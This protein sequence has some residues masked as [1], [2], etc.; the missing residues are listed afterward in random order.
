VKAVLLDTHIVLWWFESAAQVSTLARKLIEDPGVEVF[1][2]AASAWE[3]A[4]KYKAGKL[5]AA[6]SL[7]SRFADALEQE[8]FTELPVAVKHAIAAGLL[9]TRHKDPFDRVLIAQARLEDLAIVSTDSRLD[10]YDVHRVW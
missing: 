7:I 3:I 4:I 5:E 6:A 10:Q 8:H 9:E 1:V 2:S